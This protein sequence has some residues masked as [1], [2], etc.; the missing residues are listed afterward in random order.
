MNTPKSS[1]IIL[2]RMRAAATTS[3]RPDI[4]TST[5]NRLVEACNDI[6]SGTAAEMLGEHEKG[7]PN[8]RQG[9]ITPSAIERYV[10]ARRK[11]DSNWRGP[12]RV[13]IQKNSDF[14]AYVSAREDER[15]VGE[16]PPR[17]KLKT[18]D[19]ESI[20]SAVHSTEERMMLRHLL[21]AGRG[22]TK[23]LG[24]LKAGLRK[25][26]AIRFEEL[27]SAAGESEQQVSVGMMQ[28]AAHLGQSLSDDD[29]QVLR[30]M[31]KRLTNVDELG[32][33]GLEFENGRVRH[34]LTKRALLK[35]AELT[36]L[37]RLS[38]VDSIE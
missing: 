9:R 25:I 19:I 3:T 33:V 4:R 8:L 22:A 21:Q 6:Q 35:P 23:E 31:V 37:K 30:T 14:L 2:S 20:I 24:I 5:I 32:R 11:T 16:R 34:K 15:L 7:A 17:G 36:L 27:L 1:E 10:R 12:T 18:R 28:L 38:G 29:T 26:P 13:T